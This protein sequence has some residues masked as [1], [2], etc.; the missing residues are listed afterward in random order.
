MRYFAPLMALAFALAWVGGGSS[1]APSNEPPAAPQEVRATVAPDL[2]LFPVSRDGWP[3]TPTPTA[4]PTPS[5]TPEP[6]LCLWKGAWWECLSRAEMLDLLERT[7]W[8]EAQW[9]NALRV[10]K[11]ESGWI[12][13]AINIGDQRDGLHSTGLFQLWSGW[14]RAAGLSYDDWRDPDVN[15][16]A[17]L[18]AWQTSGWSPWSCRFELTR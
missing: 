17:A 14:Y 15:A 11:C 2:V 6:L 18:V 8:P 1:G 12:P 13:E 4:V 3:P 7:G 10:T 16:R 9:E 5:P